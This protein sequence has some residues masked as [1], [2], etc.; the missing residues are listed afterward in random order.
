MKKKSSHPAKIRVSSKDQKGILAN[1][2]SAVS[3]CEANIVSAQ[4]STSGDGRAVI[5]FSVDVADLEQL[6]KVI[7]CVHQVKGVFG[8]ERIRH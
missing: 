1:I 6:N 5:I 4:V 2:S 3:N 8:V 7:N